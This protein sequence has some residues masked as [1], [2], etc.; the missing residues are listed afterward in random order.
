VR[1]DELTKD[2]TGRWLVV[3]QGST[4][5]WDLD[6]K[7]VVRQPGPTSLSGTFDADGEPLK[8]V[9]VVRWPKVGATFELFFEHPDVLSVFG[10][11]WRRSS[12]IDSIQSYE[13]EK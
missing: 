11:K 12:L 3:T 1:V 4:H 5:L 10:E 13:E 2:M 8:I 9:E 7:T 6:D